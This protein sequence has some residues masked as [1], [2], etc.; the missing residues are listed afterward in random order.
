[1]SVTSNVLMNYLLDLKNNLF[2]YKIN[3]S[4][5]YSEQCDPSF[6]YGE[7]R[8]TLR[9]HINEVLWTGELIQ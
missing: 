4:V 8:I 3:G 6:S 5:I 7:I 1:M 9:F 2:D